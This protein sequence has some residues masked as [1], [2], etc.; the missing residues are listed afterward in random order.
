MHTIEDKLSQLGLTLPPPPQPAGNYLP[1]RASG[2]VLYLAGVLP[3]RDG[4]L[5]HR[6]AVGREQTVAAAREAARVCTLN[7]LAAIKGV[8]GSLDRVGQFLL[9]T[10]YVQ[11][12]EGFSD[13][14]AVINGASDLLVEV[15]GEAGRHARAAVSVN[16][17]PGNATVELQITLEVA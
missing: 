3:L 14:P 9:L 8:L 13:S 1:C 15:F 17:L 16:G 2:K 12:A 11:G 5:T 7:A 6:G 10:G 4:A